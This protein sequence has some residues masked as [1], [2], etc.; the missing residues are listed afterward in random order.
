MLLRS[1]VE[2]DGQASSSSSPGTSISSP[3]PI[4][5]LSIHPPTLGEA[6]TDVS[7]RACYSPSRLAEPL[8]GV[9]ANQSKAFDEGVARCGKQESFGGSCDDKVGMEWVA[10]SR[11]GSNALGLATVAV[12]TI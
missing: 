3:L 6:V 7:P 11:D 5:P 9:D 8:D 4:S 12:A 2:P 10:E 1:T